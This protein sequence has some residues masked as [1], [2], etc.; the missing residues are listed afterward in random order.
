M[1]DTKRLGFLNRYLT[2]WIFVAM[3]I[4]VG[5]GYFIPNLPEVYQL[6]SEGNHKYSYSYRFNIND[7]PSISKSKLCAFTKSI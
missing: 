1:S 3:F 2:L 4:G 6:F 7:V 5:L